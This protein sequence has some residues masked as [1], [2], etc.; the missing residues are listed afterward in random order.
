MPWYFWVSL[1]FAVIL[2][3]TFLAS[4]ATYR[5][6]FYSNRKTPEDIYDIPIG[7]QYEEEKERM[8]SLIEEMS[9]VPFERVYTTSRDGLK[10]SGRYYQVRDEAPFVLQVHGYKGTAVRD[11]CGGNKFAREEGYNS[12]VI[13][14]RAHGE[15]EGKTIAFG[16]QERYDVLCWVEYILQ[17]FG[18][19]TP[20]YIYGI[21]MGAA[22]ALLAASLGLPKNVK[23]IVADCPYSSPE[24]IIGKACVEMGVSPKLAMPFLRLGARVFGGFTLKGVSVAEEVKKAKIPLL[25]IH[26]ED[27]LLVPCEMSQRI[28]ENYAGKKT[29][30][31]FPKSGHGISYIVHTAE[32]EESLR[33]F[34]REVETR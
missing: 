17:R 14:H 7:E 33:Q 13:D 22:T 1:V 27:D 20:V 24:E 10:L 21:S 15:S 16:I 26:G 8:I 6:A 28:F 9:K 18:K 31:L 12:I 30:K 23:G 34:I 3:L 5:I 29:L 4:Y 32:Y 25:L 11:F 2:F 19:D